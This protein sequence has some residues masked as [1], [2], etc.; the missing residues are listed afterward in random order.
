MFR[1]TLSV[2]SAAALLAVGGLSTTAVARQGGDYRVE[3]RLRTGTQLE[4]KGVYRERARG[5]LTDQRF[6]VEVSGATPGDQYEVKIDGSPVA[7]LVVNALGR[8]EI[9]FH[10]TMDNNP[11]PDDQPLPS[12]FPHINAGQTLTVGTLSGTFQAR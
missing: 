2:L 1:K 3:A 9:E 10:S 11:G 6:T 8:A 5:S 12:D 7:I 4:A